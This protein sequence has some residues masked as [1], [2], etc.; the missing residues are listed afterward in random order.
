MESL[1]EHIEGKAINFKVVIESFR[2]IKLEEYNQTTDEGQRW[3]EVYLTEKSS[4]N[5]S[6]KAHA[7]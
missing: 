3:P 1:N 4:Q 5:Y 2:A 6:I 7:L